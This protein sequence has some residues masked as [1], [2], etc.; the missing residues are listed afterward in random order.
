MKRMVLLSLVAAHG[1]LAAQTGEAL[2]PLNTVAMVSE[3]YLRDDTRKLEIDQGEGETT[4]G[5]Y[6][7]T[8][9]PNSICE[10]GNI[11]NL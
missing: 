7:V 11:P 8:S 9:F 1:V 6:A 5:R 2:L 4:D 3:T 10:R